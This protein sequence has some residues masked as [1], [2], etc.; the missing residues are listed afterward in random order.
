MMKEM[1]EKYALDESKMVGGIVGWILGCEHL[2]AVLGIVSL[3]LLAY[4]VYLIEAAFLILLSRAL[5]VGEGL[6]TL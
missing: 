2:L 1:A 5:L 6:D 3:Y 4:G